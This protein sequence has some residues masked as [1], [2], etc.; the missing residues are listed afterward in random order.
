LQL[1]LASPDGQPRDPAQVLDRGAD[2]V[3][4]R[5]GVVD[6]VDRHFVDAQAGALGKD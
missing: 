4:P 6:P 3:D 2:D 1:G 5:V